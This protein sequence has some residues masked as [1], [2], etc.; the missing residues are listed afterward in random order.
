MTRRVALIGLS[1]ITGDLAGPASDVVLGTATPY[2][3][4]SALAAI[5]GV[6]VV[7]GC[8]IVPAAR[9][10]F[11][12]RWQPRWPA[13]RTYDDYHEMLA[14][15]QPDVVGIATPDHLHTAPLLAAIGDG[16][17]GILC[18]KP[19]A[20]SLEEADRVIE[21]ART[22]GTTINVNYTRRWQPEWVEARRIVRNQDIGRLSQ[23]VA[24]IG[25]PRA[26]LFR[27][28]T[29]VM[30]LVGFV[31]DAPPEWVIA[32]L[33]PGYEGYG[34]AYRGDGG[35]DPATEPG[36]NYYIG[37][38][39]GVRAYVTGMKDTVGDELMMHLIGSDGRLI[40][41]M[42]GMRIQGMQNTDIRTTAGVPSVKPV[43]PSFTVSGIQAAWLDLFRALDTGATVH[44]APETARR[45]VALT[46]AILLSQ[47]RGN[48]RVRLDELGAREPL[49][50]T[51]SFRA[52]EPLAANPAGTD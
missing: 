52:R 30:D 48:V 21:A 3:H 44:S 31:A 39:N 20:T 40:I 6:D 32:E 18:E 10:R 34:T 50:A 16:V 33:E 47:Q 12:D 17:R 2:S 11:Q 4:A 7:A 42:E 51:E 37:F 15:E 24:E 43:R 41:D 38:E 46:E 25:G 29:H 28:H 8:D 27:N 35:N 1:W 26:M 19:L 5:P 22:A 36:A 49:G 14:T 9:E 45:T 13:L 23:I